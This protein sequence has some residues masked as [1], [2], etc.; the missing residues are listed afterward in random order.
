MNAHA[1][2]FALHSRLGER[3]VPPKSNN[4]KN[5]SALRNAISLGSLAF[6]VS[7]FF[8]GSAETVLGTVN[9]ATGFIILASIIGVAVVADVL[10]VAVAAAEEAP[11]HAMASD[12][13]AGAKEAVG[14]VRNGARV[15]SICADVIGDICGTVSGAIGAAIVLDLRSIYPAVPSAILS[16]LVIGMIAAVTVGSKAFTK[17]FAIAHA[18]YIVGKAARTW[19]VIKRL[20]PLRRRRRGSS[21]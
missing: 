12:R 1:V 18:N 16:M 8:S 7:L 13:V 17:G 15:N 2:I 20:A 9:I 11:F 3:H 4:G 14:L 21:T 19:Y 6:V 5:R 10:A